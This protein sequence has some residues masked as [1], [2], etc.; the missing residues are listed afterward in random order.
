L[1]LA[2]SL[3]RQRNEQEEPL[4]SNRAAGLIRGGGTEATPLRCLTAQL[5]TALGS[6]NVQIHDLSALGARI[7]AK[8]L[9]APGMIVCLQRGEVA[10]FGIMAWIDENQ[11][12]VLFD[13]ELD[14]QLFGAEPKEAAAA[15]IASGHSWAGIQEKPN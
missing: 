12:G 5:R 15:A 3:G 14:A 6:Y 4:G 13:E 7:E 9:P 1:V 8:R 10:V 2:H 11:G